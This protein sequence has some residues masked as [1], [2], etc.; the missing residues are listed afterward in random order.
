[1]EEHNYRKGIIAASITALLWGFLPIILKISLTA[2]SPVDV[3]WARFAISFIC[4]FLYHLIWKPRGLRI[5]LKPP[6]LIILAAI[7]LGLNYLGLISGVHL[8]TPAIAE[9]FI[10]SGAILL[11]ISGFL[12][13]K[14]RASR[15]QVGG[16]LIVVTGLGLFYRE[17][18]LVLAENLM[19]YQ[20]GVA[21]TL[22]G[23]TMWT[24]YALM[25]KKLVRSWD[26]LQL[27][28]LLFGI[29]S[30]GYLPFVN[31]H[32]FASLSLSVWGV[33]IFLGLNTLIAYGAI[34]Y[35]LKFLPASRVSVIVTLNP[36]ITF[37][38]IA[39]LMVLEVSWVT[40]ENFT[41]VSIL[42]AMMVVAGAILTIRKPKAS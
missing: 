18:I 34:A 41:V 20:K 19:Q 42:G 8:T 24:C 5:M 38:T 40:P 4:L 15:M 16:L 3:S 12:F 6:P 36:I 13:F 10:Q 9:V 37:S 28:L 30:I 1:M 33:V 27:N 29:P 25:Q 35:A 2:L 31:F 14:E 23:G 26:P 21:L 22:F 39:I 32:A 17:Q 11:A 7:C